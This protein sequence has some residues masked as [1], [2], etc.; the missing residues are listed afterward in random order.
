MTAPALAGPIRSA[1]LDL[2]SMS[3]AFLE[4]LLTGRRSDAERLLGVPIPE[5]WPGEI[6]HAAKL[7]RDQ[8]RADPSTQ[9]WLLRAM[10]LRTT[11]PLAVGS[12][13]FHAPP[14][15]RGAVEVGYSTL[16]PYR[17]RGYAREAVLAFFGWARHQGARTF[18]ASVSPGNDPSLGL[19]RS[20]GFEQ[21]GEQWDDIDGLELVF[22]VDASAVRGLVG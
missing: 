4:A 9:P 22:E 15:A 3:P 17:R 6:L 7:R 16:E 18:V 5:E 10:V 19:I 11:H 8:M 14:D 1:R 21:T 20:L 13:N 2:R 12:I